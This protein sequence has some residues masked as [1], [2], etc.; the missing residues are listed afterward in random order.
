MDKRCRTC[1]SKVSKVA[2]IKMDE[3]RKAHDTIPLDDE[4]M[5]AMCRSIFG[6]NLGKDN[7]LLVDNK[8]KAQ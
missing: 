5:E 3:W 4:Q 2:I 6:N 8:C 1:H 7:T